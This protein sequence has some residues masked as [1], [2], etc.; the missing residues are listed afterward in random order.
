MTASGTIPVIAAPMFDPGA[1][2][3]LLR[4]PDTSTIAD[5][6]AAALPGLAKDAWARVRVTL[7]NRKGSVVLD[8]ARWHRIRARVGTHVI[9]RLIPAGD[10]LRGILQI[11]VSIA[12]VALG[13]FWAPALA[14]ATGL[15]IGAAQGIIGLGV[16]A[17]GGLLIN[18][19]V[20]PVKA[21]KDR[22]SYQISGMRN[23][24]RPDGVVPLVLGKLRYA[25]PFAASS[26]SEIAGDWQYVRFLL[27]AGYG[28]VVCSDLRIG[29]TAIEEYD[30]VDLEL[31]DGVPAD[32]NISLYPRQVYEEAIGTELT[33]PVPRDD[34]GKVIS[35]PAIETPVIRYTGLDASGACAIFSY[36]SGLVSYDKKG[37]RHPMTVEI[38]IRQRLAGTSTWQYVELCSIQRR[39]V[40]GFNVSYE[41]KFP[42]R[43]RW[44]IEF[45]RMTTEHTSDRIQSR[46]VLSSLQ[47]MRPEYPIFFSQPLSLIAGRV[48]A[49]HQLNG[50]LDTINAMCSRHCLDW[51]HSSGTWII[52]ETSNPASLMRFVLESGA[53]ARPVPAYAMDMEWLQDWHEFCRVHNLKYDRVIDFE[54]SLLDLLTEICAAGRARPRHDGILWG[55]VID[56]PQTLIVKDHINPRNSHSFRAS[57]MYLR[58]P[59]AFRVKFLDATNDYQPAE[60]IIPWPGHVGEITVIEELE[61]PGKT[62]PAEIW[63]EARR[64]MYEVMH[65]PDSY[66]V[67][68]E[69]P[70]RV[71]TRGDKVV[72]STDVIDRTQFAGRVKFAEGRIV[73]LDEEV[74]MS[75]G[76]TYALRWRI[77]VTE[78]NPVGT[79]IVREVETR[80]GKTTVLHMTGSDVPPIGEIVHFG[81]LATLDMALIV[82]GI[83]AGTDFSS[84]IHMVDAAVII[85]TLTDAEVPPPW[86]G[87]VGGE[88]DPNLDAPQKPRITR[89]VTGIEGTGSLDGIVVFVQPRGGPVPTSRIE[90]DHRLGTSGAWSTINVPPAAGGVTLNGYLRGNTVQVR[91]R[92]L[93]AEGTPSEYSVTVTVLV[94]SEDGDLPALLDNGLVD[95]VGGLGFATVKWTATPD[96]TTAQVQVYRSTSTTLDR[97]TDA[98]GDPVPTRPGQ[99]YSLIVGDGTRKNLIENGGFS[100]GDANW[101]LH[102]SWYV[103]NGRLY[104][105]PD[106]DGDAAQQIDVTPGRWCR[107]SFRT[108]NMIAGS[109]TPQLIGGTMISGTAVT[110][111]GLR[112]DR[113]QAVTGTSRLNFHGTDTLDGSIDD[114]V[115]FIETNKCLEQG[116]HRFWL[117][118]Q[119]ENGIPGPVLGPITVTVT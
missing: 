101:E 31:R 103:N 95:I 52:R 28:R 20:P 90:I 43:G 116:T 79:S 42:S 27:T 38:R 46:S 23:E 110:T 99:N 48:K 57:R 106:F 2:R 33:R 18:A 64:R 32:G 51:D 14:G 71:V 54:I 92:A 30:E 104:H 24:M 91:A 63:I 107:I 114:I 7:V 26:F 56:R 65:R 34:A 100:S 13:Q 119:N 96:A 12:A 97:E 113:L 47:T 66:S 83:E 29:E 19:L 55:G 4:L 49:T 88:I 69:G 50:S 84:I 98:V 82:T 39:Q 111:N 68:Q 59:H 115:L 41:W 77:G 80:P 35:G 3:R 74:T 25:P 81:E 85:D 5:F 53:L 73:E 17:L 1:G 21:D 11:V 40:E 93:S 70:A 67:I 94:G 6:V 117:E 10:E 44:E 109:V 102:S 108:R 75:T 9:I 118:P 72:L 16:T 36:P 89:V 8:P 61:L 86:S 45:T 105:M 62:N 58:L 15:S 76:T 87:R 37:K 60:R 112:R 78:E 22:P